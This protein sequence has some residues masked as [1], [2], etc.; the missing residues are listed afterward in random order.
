MGLEP[1]LSHPDHL[2][3]AGRLVRTVPVPGEIL[4][5]APLAVVAE[6]SSPTAGR[7]E[8]V[9]DNSCM[10]HT[11]SNSLDELAIYVAVKGVEFE[12]LEP[13][14]LIEHLAVVAG[15]LARAARRS[16]WLC[17]AE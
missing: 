9:D 10:L 7:L 1:H 3:A 13:P 8:P 11:G 2:V 15:R 6:R 5:H 4:L 14:E 17:V 12:V 16:Q